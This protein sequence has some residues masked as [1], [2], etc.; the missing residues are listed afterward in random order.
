VYHR[1]PLD[2]K[3]RNSRVVCI[4]DLKF[5]PAT[6]AILP[7]VITKDGVARDPVK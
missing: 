7:V 2:Q 3:D 6:G 1:R 4:D 5:D